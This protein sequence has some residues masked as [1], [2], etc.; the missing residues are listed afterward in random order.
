VRVCSVAA[1]GR[2]NLAASSTGEV[3]A[4]ETDDDDEHGRPLGQGELMNFPV[5]KPIESLRGIKVIAV[6][7]GELHMMA[8]SE[9][10]GLYAW[11]N[12]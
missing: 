6:V 7:A 9:D 2:R 5:P 1:Y 12:D 4:W 3:W 11:G 10:G 8:L